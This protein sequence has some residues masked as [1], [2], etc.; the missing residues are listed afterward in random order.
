MN[1]V[2]LLAFYEVARAGSISAGAQRL[3]VSQPAVTR[4]IRELEERLGVTLFDRLPRGVALTPAGNTLL[5]YATRIF[6]LSEAAE[7]ELTELAGLN[8]GQLLIG[9]SATVGV[10]LV[11]AVIARFNV[12]YPKVI[13][14]LTVANTEQVEQGLLAHA[15]G[16]GFIEGPYDATVFDANVIGADEI[17]AVAAVGHPLAKRRFAARELANKAVILREPGS[18][19][20]AAVEDAYKRA[21]LSMTPLMSVSHTEA[22]KRMLL[23]GQ[24]IAYVSSLSVADEIARGD[25]VRL[26]VTGVDIKRSLHVVW[27]KG[28]SFAPSTEAFVKL[29]DEQFSARFSSVIVR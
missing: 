15:F 12:L 1:F 24:A 4:E 26:R 2:H 27:L 20:R 3:H 16:L 17:I 28:R 6:A 23:S 9:A 22:I 13:V 19:T 11:P 8:A 29:F 21:G 10:Y 18:G 25:L 14:E 7:R 5:E